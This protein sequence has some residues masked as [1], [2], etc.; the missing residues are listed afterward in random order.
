MTDLTIG[1]ALISAGSAVA[2]S[3]L[4]ILT[5]RIASKP[6]ADQVV[7]NRLTALAD[8]QEKERKKME[9]VTADLEIMVIRLVEWADEVTVI[10]DRRNVKLPKRP[11][12]ANLNGIDK[13]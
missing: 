4:T 1:V 13:T 10:A 7:L 11:K 3:I 2:A 12:F 9:A 5:T 8:L 6:A